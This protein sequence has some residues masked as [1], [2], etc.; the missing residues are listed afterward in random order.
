M[1]G[2]ITNSFHLV[3]RDFMAFAYLLRI[4]VFRAYLVEPTSSRI[5]LI[6]FVATSSDSLG[7][8]DS[9]RNSFGSS[10]GSSFG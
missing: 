10:F 5:V 1:L 7:S 3:I 8:L 2:I 9:F 4:L 6:V